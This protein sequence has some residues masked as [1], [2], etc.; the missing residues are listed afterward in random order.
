MKEMKNLATPTL[1]FCERIIV[2]RNVPAFDERTTLWKI[3][4]CVDVRTFSATV[5]KVTAFCNSE[6]YC[7]LKT[8]WREERNFWKVVAFLELE[9][10]LAARDSWRVQ[11]LWG[12]KASWEAFCKVNF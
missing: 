9:A 2:L 10:F 12:V 4:G 6:T 1:S 8:G 7:T 11:S 3:G 5:G